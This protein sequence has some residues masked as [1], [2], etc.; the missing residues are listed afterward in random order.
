MTTGTS[1]DRAIRG[2]ATGSSVS[3]LLVVVA[4][5]LF[6]AYRTI[7]A[8]HANTANFLTEQTW[9]PDG[10]PP[11]FGI[12]AALYFTLVTSAIAMLLAVP[13][14]LAAA[15]FITFYAPRRR[16]RSG[17]AGILTHPHLRTVR[18]RRGE[19]GLTPVPARL[20]RRPAADHPDRRAEPAGPASRPAVRRRSAVR[21]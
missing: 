18:H 3:V 16:V 4:I 10:D 1:T 14:A 21:R 7:P 2:L 5:A 19:H 11:R 6:L 9:Q 15:L 13:V 8:L 20:G 17:T 12:P